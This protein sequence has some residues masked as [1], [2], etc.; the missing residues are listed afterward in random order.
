M[1]F[2]DHP[3]DVVLLQFFSLFVVCVVVLLLWP[4]SSFLLGG[5]A[6]RAVEARCR[7]FLLKVR[8]GLVEVWNLFKQ[9]LAC[10]VGCVHLLDKAAGI[11]DTEEV[12]FVNF[13]HNFGII[14]SPAQNV[15]GDKFVEQ[16]L[17]GLCG[18]LAL[19]DRCLL[20]V[21]AHFGAEVFDDGAVRHSECVGDIN[22]V[23]DVGLHT[24]QATL[25][26]C[27]QR[28]HVIPEQRQ[29]VNLS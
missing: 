16:L 3:G 19:H 11:A 10:L 1:T 6:F 28:W 14:A 5:L 23:G 8:V 17:K 27:F 25:L 2:L 18:V 24:V 15:L 22:K 21:G 26:L 7:L 29:C 12:F 13:V 9:C 20:L 4:L